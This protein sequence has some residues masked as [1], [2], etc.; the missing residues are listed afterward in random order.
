[1][2]S[3]LGFLAM[4]GG[5]S[6]SFLLDDND[7][8]TS[9]RVPHHGE[10]FNPS[11]PSNALSHLSGCWVI[12]GFTIPWIQ[13]AGRLAHSGVS[14]RPAARR[15]LLGGVVANG[16]GKT[17]VVKLRDFPG[18]LPLRAANATTSTVECAGQPPDVRRRLSGISRSRKVRSTSSSRHR[19]AV[20]PFT[21]LFLLLRGAKLISNQRSEIPSHLASHLAFIALLSVAQ[22][23][24]PRPT[25]GIG[26]ASPGAEV[27]HRR[28]AV[29]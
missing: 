14:Q 11:L 21:R 20:T 28:H 19:D 10:T 24:A 12:T 6:P 26:K 8:P 17:A 22:T 3:L 18:R 4:P 25:I 23:V 15:S 29:H 2:R 1:V 27:I 9:T 7:K 13:R 5:A 16:R